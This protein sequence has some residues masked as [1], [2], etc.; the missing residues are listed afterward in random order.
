MTIPP[1]D[2][3]IVTADCNDES[4]IDYL[5]DLNGYLIIKGAV[6]PEDIA[7]MNAW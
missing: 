2:I 5:F 1:A 4:L 7:E 6:A 3:P